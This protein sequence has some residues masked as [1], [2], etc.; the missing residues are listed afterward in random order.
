M[1]AARKSTRIAGRR[2]EPAQRD[3]QQSRDRAGSRRRRRAAMPT[4]PPAEHRQRARRPPTRRCRRGTAPS[5]S[6]RAA[7]RAR[8][9]SAAPSIRGD[10]RGWRCRRCARP[11]ASAAPCERHPEVVPGEHHDGDA[12]HRG[13]EELLAHAARHLRDAVGA[14]RDDARRPR[15]PAAMPAASQ[16]FRP[17]TS[18]VAAATMPTISAASRTSRK[19]MTAVANMA[20]LVRL[21]GDDRR[22]WRSSRCIR[23]RRGSCRA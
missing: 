12:E 2:E 4:R 10:R 19:T 7:R 9:R 11:C 6:L 5:R 13:V 15:D 17:G 1:P 22:P 23:R 18:R 16:R 3:A 21:F 14:E 20:A 8:R